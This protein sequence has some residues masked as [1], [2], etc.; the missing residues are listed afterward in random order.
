MSSGFKEAIILGDCYEHPERW[1]KNLAN[2]NLLAGYG[3]LDSYSGSLDGLQDNL[4]KDDWYFG[5]LSYD[6]KSEIHSHDTPEAEALVKFDSLKFFRPEWLVIVDK[7]SCRLGY[8]P[9]KSDISKAQEFLA[10]LKKTTVLKS[11]LQKAIDLQASISEEEY[12]ADI[13]NIQNH[14]QRGE[15]YEMNYCMEFVAH[16]ATINPQQTFIRLIEQS[17]MPFCAFVKQNK[18]YALSASPER[19][20]TKRASRLYSMPMKGTAS[21]GKNSTEEKAN[22][23]L[24][25]E[26]DKERAENIMI[27]DLLRNDLSMVASKSTVKVEELCGLYSFPRVFQLVSTISAELDDSKGLKEIIGATFPM[28]SMT[29]APKISAFEII[30]KYEKRKRGL[31]SG[32]IGYISPEKDFDFNVVIRTLLYDENKG[33]LSYTTG[34]AITALSEVG[35][36]YKECLLKADIM[37][38]ILAENNNI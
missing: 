5:Y 7:A 26:S 19:Y 11:G 20:L 27:C 10:E 38:N 36:E 35:Q 9:N 18:L 28:G 14:I 30:G 2:F 33:S 8:D 17:P 6:L 32:A 13:Q 21:R 31:Y 34:S 22:R 4:P 3:A 24:L 25:T 12:K 1:Y 23:R 29:G 15:L 16:N 37:R